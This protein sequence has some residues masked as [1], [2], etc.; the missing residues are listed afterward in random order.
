[1]RDVF[2]LNEA[3]MAELEKER[4]GAQT[5]AAAELQ[6]MVSLFGDILAHRGCKGGLADW[7]EAALRT[8]KLIE[9]GY[10]GRASPQL[11]MAVSRFLISAW[12]QSEAA[13]PRES[14]SLFELF[15]E[16]HSHL[17]QLHTA[18]AEKRGRAKGKGQKRERNGKRG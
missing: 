6:L 11:I 16:H 8:A 5:V 14:V 12:Q 18:Q 2:K 1:M 9:L 7:T 4:R 13:V 10:R 3:M 17:N 15:M